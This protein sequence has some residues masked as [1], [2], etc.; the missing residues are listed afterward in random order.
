WFEVQD[1][2]SQ[3]ICQKMDPKP[4][5]NIWDVCAGGGGKSLLLAAMMENKGRIVATDLRSFKLEELKKRAKRAGVFNIFPAELERLAELKVARKGFDKILVDAP[6]SGTG[7]LGRNPDAKWKLAPSWFEALP[8]EQ[9]AIL[10]KALPYLAKNGK[11]YYATCS[12]EAAEN[13]KVVEKFLSA[14]PEL[15]TIPCGEKGD[16]F[17]KL[18]PPETGTDGFF[19]AVFEKQISSNNGE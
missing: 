5:E 14:H 15:R 18:W 10:E 6:C 3:M 8:V 17:F 16:P 7:T 9:L 12:V 4:G 11:L 13:E 19:L 1:E 2:G